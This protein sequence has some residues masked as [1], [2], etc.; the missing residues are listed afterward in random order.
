MRVQYM[1]QN[2]IRPGRSMPHIQVRHILHSSASPDVSRSMDFAASSYS[3][4]NVFS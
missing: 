1:M 3:S 2:Y 4:V